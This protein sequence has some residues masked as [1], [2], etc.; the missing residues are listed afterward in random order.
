MPSGS[1]NGVDGTQPLAS[2]FCGRRTLKEQNEAHTHTHQVEAE[3]Y[4]R[5]LSNSHTLD[6]YIK[7]TGLYSQFT[8][9]DL[10][11]WPHTHTHS[12]TQSLTLRQHKTIDFFTPLP[13][14]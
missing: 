2:E 7:L 12:L 1:F 10:P 4:K 3:W 8:W 14:L 13:P 11:N 9:A 6:F 5:R